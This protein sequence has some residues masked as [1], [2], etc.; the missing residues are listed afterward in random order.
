GVVR[1]R[2]AGRGVAGVVGAGVAGVA[3]GQVPREARPGGGVAGLEAVARVAIVADVRRADADTGRARVVR[4]ARVAVVAE[5][6]GVGRVH[7]AQQRVA[8]VVGAGVAVVTVG[9]RPRDASPGRGVAGLDAVA[10]VTV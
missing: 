1:V 6:R 2:A 4:R 9:W 5:D 3:D 7:A 8:A 10:R